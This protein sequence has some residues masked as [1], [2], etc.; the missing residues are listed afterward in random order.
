MVMLSY[1]LPVIRPTF[2]CGVMVNINIVSGLSLLNVQTVRK[3]SHYIIQSVGS[4][5]AEVWK[6]L[7]VTLL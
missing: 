7:Y 3:Q 6:N 5:A 2:Y 4:S 1:K